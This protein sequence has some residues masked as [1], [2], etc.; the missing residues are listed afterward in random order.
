L[1]SVPG[2]TSSDVIIDIEN[3]LTA[4]KWRIIEKPFGLFQLGT[5]FNGSVLTIANQDAGTP[6]Q[7]ADAQN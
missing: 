3:G 2:S 7:L 4:Q 5:T 6:I 1:S